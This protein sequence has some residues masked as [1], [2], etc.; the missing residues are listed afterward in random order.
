[1]NNPPIPF[2]AITEINIISHLAE[3]Q[4]AKFLPVGVTPAQFGVLNH[5]LRLARNETIGQLASAQQVTQPTMSSTV[6]KLEDAGY[7]VLI[8]DDK[9]RR[10]RNV[11]VTVKGAEMH[12]SVIENI[13]AN[14]DD[15]M[16]HLSEDEWLTL[17]VLLSRLR[18]IMDENR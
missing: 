6:R 11:Q 18:K 14:T 4:L 10:I 7:V 13:T 5:I 12:R 1:M 2:A 9:D 8:H 15:L 16:N 17:H 3:N